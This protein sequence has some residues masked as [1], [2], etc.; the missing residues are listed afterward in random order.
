MKNFFQPRVFAT[1]LLL[2]SVVTGVTVLAAK[3]RRESPPVNVANKTRA[4]FV[5]SATEVRANQTSRWVKLELQNGYDSAIIAFS[6]KSHN[7]VTKGGSFTN[8]FLVQYGQVIAPGEIITHEYGMHPTQDIIRVQAVVFEDGTTDGNEATANQLKGDCVARR[9]QARR[10]L[11]IFRKAE[12]NADSD[13]S[14]LNEEIRK[15]LLQLPDGSAEPAS[16]SINA[17]DARTRYYS[18]GFVGGMAGAKNHLLTEMT[19]MSEE[20][21]PAKFKDSSEEDKLRAEKTHRWSLDML[22]ASLETLM[23]R[24]AKL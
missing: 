12:S 2:A 5:V 10:A 16:R 21:S 9:E 4:F 20:F 19:R 3:T 15:G 14:R 7:S 24:T 8:S 6:V 22:R 23:T 13:A 18:R 1:S 11:E 17:T